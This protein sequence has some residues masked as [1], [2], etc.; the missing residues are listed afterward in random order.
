MQQLL[1]TFAEH[2]E[3]TK[4]AINEIDAILATYQDYYQKRQLLE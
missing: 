3:M 1:E 4:N 2:I